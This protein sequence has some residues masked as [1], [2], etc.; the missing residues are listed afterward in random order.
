MQG[1][2]W[3][4]RVFPAPQNVC[5]RAKLPV[6]FDTRRGL[7]VLSRQ[8]SKFWRC[9]ISEPM[10]DA[11]SPILLFD[12]VCNLCNGLVTFILR[13]DPR[14]RF[15]FA[16]L[17][18]PAG[19]ALLAR[20]GLPTADLDTV[21]LIEGSRAFIRSTAVLRTARRMGYLWP[22]AFVF[23][24]IPRPLRDLVYKLIGKNRYRMFGR[25]EA[26]MLPTPD[27]RARFLTQAGDI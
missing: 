11:D 12:G 2:S 3:E 25:R 10:T 15:R 18:S 22:L 24:L 14:H 21:V 13:N 7:L 1:I 5:L 4:S 19:Q 6:C 17:Q 27:I 16:S 23:I 26:C 20:H 8:R 9:D